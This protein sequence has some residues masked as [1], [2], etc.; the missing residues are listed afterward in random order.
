MQK[1]NQILQKET[2]H[3]LRTSLKT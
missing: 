3:Y 2:A 1:S